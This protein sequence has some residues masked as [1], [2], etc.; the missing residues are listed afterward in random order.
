MR[1]M[2]IPD[3]LSFEW[4]MD[5]ALSPD[6]KQIAFTKTV[7][8]KDDMNYRSQLY[9]MPSCGSAA[10]RVIG[11]DKQRNTNPRWSPCGKFLAFLSNRSGSNQIWMLPFA[12]GGE[13]VQQ[14]TMR[15]GAGN[16][17]WSPD[18]TKIAFVSGMHPNDTLEKMFTPLSSKE[19]EDEA[20]YKREHGL[21][22]DALRYRSDGQGY[23]DGRNAH[24]WV[25]DV[26]TQKVTQ[27][28]SG[29]YSHQSFTWSPC[30]EYLAVA[31]N[32]QEDREATPMGSDLW[33]FPITG[34]EPKQLTNTPGPCSNPAW[35]P[36]G[37]YIAF[38]GH[39]REHRGGTI[40]RLW[41]VDAAG[42]EPRCLTANFDQGFGEVVHTDMTRTAGSSSSLFWLPGSDK[43]ISFS[44]H[45]GST[46][47]YA[48]GLDGQVAQLTQGDRF[49]YGWSLSSDAKHMVIG[50]SD[51]LVPNEFSMLNLETG[52]ETQ[53]TTNNAWLKEVSLSPAVEFWCKGDEDWDLQG[54]LVKPVDW[55]EGK[56]YPLILT[57]HGGPA[58][59]YGVAFQHTFQVMASA[60][61]YVLYLN[62]RGGQGYGQDFQLGVITKYGEGDYRDLMKAVDYTLAQHPDIDP[63]KMGVTGGSYG[64][65]MTNWIIGQTDRFAAAVTDR[66]ISNWV[67]FF[68]CSDIGFTFCESQHGDDPLTN[69]EEMVRISPLTYAKNMVTPLLLVF[70]EQDYRCPAE[71]SE[72]L[73]VALKKLGKDTKMARYPNSS[74]NLAVAGFPPL[75]MD[76]LEQM[77]NWFN[78]KMGV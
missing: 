43:V 76:R 64:G 63:L 61:Y 78:T 53:L 28:T 69:F 38:M 15:Y 68:G 72:Q 18:G 67:S 50:W 46:H 31:A 42:G 19:R 52:E 32:R 22:V 30:G 48:V 70:C 20:K 71:Q 51:S 40:S 37:K 11:A 56:K 23:L 26:A 58:N 17:V 65:F 34:G 5:P 29:S 35:S 41:V 77:M 57:I 55:E 54:W 10:P 45:H 13:A 14:T 66:S 75:R 24:I 8:D 44:A 21:V 60:G 47:L 9:L 25:L 6:G 12:A 36:D 62:P 4:I 49:V 7:I 39:Q 73:F 74:H 59:M 3:I 2:T 33:L 1:K 16:L 27:V